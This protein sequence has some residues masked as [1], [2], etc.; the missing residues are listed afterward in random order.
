MKIYAHATFCCIILFSHEFILGVGQKIK[1][2]RDKMLIFM[3][4][5]AYYPMFLSYKF[6]FLFTCPV[7]FWENLDPFLPFFCAPFGHSYL[8]VFP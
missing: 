8:C 6:V 2:L 3:F 7:R 1:C 4:A 5:I